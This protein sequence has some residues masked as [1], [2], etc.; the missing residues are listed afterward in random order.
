MLGGLT[1]CGGLL[2]FGLLELQNWLDGLSELKEQQ[3]PG[4]RVY[5]EIFVIP[6][7]WVP[8]TVGDVLENHQQKRLGT[9]NPFQ[10]AA[11][12]MRPQSLQC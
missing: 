11:Y 7:L 12:S 1:V 2:E 9:P 3:L 6:S 10:I 4:F 8:G 5:L